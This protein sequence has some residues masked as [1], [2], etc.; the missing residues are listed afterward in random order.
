MSR[1][2]ETPADCAKAGE[3]AMAAT[4]A[5]VPIERNI[6]IS[7]LKT[8]IG[9]CCLN[10]KV[11]S[12]LQ[13]LERLQVFNSDLLTVE[14]THPMR[15]TVTMSAIGRKRKF[16]VASVTEQEAAD[17]ATSRSAVAV[18][19]KNVASISESSPKLS[20]AEVSRSYL[21]FA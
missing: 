8:S 7:S 3:Q 20:S 19:S 6:F 1:W 10:R 9:L 13:Y 2:L 14:A 17:F 18:I 11:V 16:V 15:R 5:A 21:E 12:L 4:I